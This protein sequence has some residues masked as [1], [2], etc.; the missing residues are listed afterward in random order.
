MVNPFP[1]VDFVTFVVKKIYDQPQVL[2]GGFRRK[3]P[4]LPFRQVSF[5]NF[6]RSTR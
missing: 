3:F 5:S 1:F 4:Q 6:T 2:K